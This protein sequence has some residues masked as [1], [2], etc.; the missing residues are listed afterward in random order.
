M[1]TGH[2]CNSRVY[3][4]NSSGKIFDNVSKLLC[5]NISQ[6]V[7]ATTQKY[8][9]NYCWKVYSLKI[10][11][12]SHFDLCKDKGII[13]VSTPDVFICDICQNVFNN[14]EDIETHMQKHSRKRP[15]FQ[16]DQCG[17][18]FK[19]FIFYYLFSNIIFY[20]KDFFLL[21]F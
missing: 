14:H 20:I 2:P 17:I 9:C 21:G 5:F 3:Y 13:Q 12:D 8:Q 6:T 1:T 19:V 10:D 7:I 11:I 15:N 4:R 16:C 18:L